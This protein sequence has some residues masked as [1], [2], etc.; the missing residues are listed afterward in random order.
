MQGPVL[1]LQP[2]SSVI[3]GPG[4]KKATGSARLRPDIGN[5]C[6]RAALALEGSLGFF[7]MCTLDAV[8]TNR[9][10]NSYTMYYMYIVLGIIRM[11][12]VSYDCK[13]AHNA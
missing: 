13:E 6:Q 10:G 8:C 12:Y 7:F 1:S 3:S 4:L 5:I 9:T 2:L 11:I